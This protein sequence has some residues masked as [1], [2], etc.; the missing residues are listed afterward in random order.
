MSKK[1]FFAIVLSVL[2]LS[3]CILGTHISS[4]AEERT[5]QPAKVQIELDSRIENMLKSNRVYNDTFY[6][7]KELAEEVAISLKDRAVEGYIATKAVED[8]VFAMYSIN[9]DASS[10]SYPNIPSVDGYMPLVARGYTSYSHKIT[11]VLDEGDGA[12]TVYSDVTVDCH[13]GNP[14]V[15]PCE[16]LFVLCEESPFGYNIVYSNITE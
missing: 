13:D 9:I 12:V 2:L 15:L 4:S 5:V 11:G 6:N 14:E 3:C 7:Q 8:L 16:T 1:G 10:I